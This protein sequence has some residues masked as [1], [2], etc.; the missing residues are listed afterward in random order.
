[1]IDTK[2]ALKTKAQRN[3]VFDRNNRRKKKCMPIL[4]SNDNKQF[5]DCCISVL[6]CFFF[7]VRWHI[8]VV[9]GKESFVCLSGTTTNERTNER[10]QQ[11]IT[12]PAS[13]TMFNSEAASNSSSSRDGN[14]NKRLKNNWKLENVRD[15]NKPKRAVSLCYFDVRIEINSS[16]Y[17]FAICLCIRCALCTVSIAPL[18]APRVFHSLPKTIIATTHTTYIR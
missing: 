2:N 17:A 8:R 15:N 7:C 1:M 5:F 11:Q 10:K 3:S 14:N 13:S 6:F 12:T 4:H 18:P 16:R 9:G